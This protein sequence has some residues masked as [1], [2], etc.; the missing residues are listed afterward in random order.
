[1]EG[2]LAGSA[3]RFYFRSVAFQRSMRLRAARAAEVTSGAWAS[4]CWAMAPRPA[5]GT[6]HRK[7]TEPEGSPSTQKRVTPRAFM[8]CFRVVQD[9]SGAGAAGEPEGLW[10]LVR[11]RVSGSEVR[12]AAWRRRRSGGRGGLGGCWYGARR[13]RRVRSRVRRPSR[14]PRRGAAGPAR[15]SG[16]EGRRGS[17]AG[18]NAGADGVEGDGLGIGVGLEFGS[19]GGGAG[20]IGVGGVGRGSEVGGGGIR[21]R[22][23]EGWGFGGVASGVARG[24]GSGGCGSSRGCGFGT[25]GDGGGFDVEGGGG[26]SAEVGDRAGL[27]A[28]EALEPGEAGA[29]DEG[30]SG[31][32]GQN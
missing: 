8:A 29:V 11:A 5:R 3:R 10:R 18:G 13:R 6:T 22:Q 19:R 26:L 21:A 16:L 23:G 15:A 4:N 2:F 28:H 1:M 17:L 12:R 24:E 20:G 14:A 25:D 7:V 31:E 30:A 32:G 27:Q 9:A